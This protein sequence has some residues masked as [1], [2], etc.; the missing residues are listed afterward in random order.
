MSPDARGITG[1]YC[2][3]NKCKKIPPW[4]KMHTS[5]LFSV[6]RHIRWKMSGWLRIVWQASTVRWWSAPSLSTGAACTR[7]SGVLTGN[8]P[9]VS[10]PASVEAIQCVLLY[11]SLGHYRCFNITITIL[12]IIHRPVFYLKLNSTLYVCSHLTGITLRLHYEPNRLILS[13]GLWRRY[14]N[15][16]ITILDIIDRPAFY[17]K[18]N[19]SETGFCLRLQVKPTQL[20]PIDTASLSTYH[21]HKPIDLKIGVAGNISHSAAKIYRRTIRH[22]PHSCSDCQ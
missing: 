2:I 6:D 18:H 10:N 9:L 19:V 1:F 20:G 17:L 21:H 11:P 4:D 8:S 22:V 13:V 16:T 15:I 5:I 3:Y 14:I 7:T 12:H